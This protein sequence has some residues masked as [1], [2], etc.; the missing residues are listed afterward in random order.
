MLP[1][2][3]ACTGAD[4]RDK[5]GPETVTDPTTPPTSPWTVPATEPPA[6]DAQSLGDSL[7]RILV[8]TI[9]LSAMPALDVY[10][11]VMS[12]G[13]GYCPYTY[14]YATGYYGGYSLA[15]YSQ[16]ESPQ[17][18]TFSGYAG[19]YRSS[20]YTPES[21]Y[22]GVYASATV[23]LPN[24]DVMTAA[25]YW[26]HSVADYGSE[27]YRYEYLDGAFEF[28]GAA[29]GSWV[30][31]GL[32]PHE[33]EVSSGAAANGAWSYRYVNGQYSGIRGDVDTVDY[34]DVYFD[35]TYDC[36][37][38][39]GV[40]ALRTADA[41]WYEITFSGDPGEDGGCDGCGTAR[42]RGLEVGEV[43]GDF[44]PWTEVP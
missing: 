39:S 3:L 11:E 7:D 32:Q 1:L 9:A 22:R 34:G 21:G 38:P 2:L 14:G 19:D 42:W 44:S 6:F 8:D 4:P 17:G 25:G 33:L 24:G 35:T 41:D 20:G 26:A 15:W 29:P 36:A 37:E 40:V 10:D 5:D 28:D 31:D 16:C 12:Y 13:G 18:A 43:C 27:I 30:D 23:V